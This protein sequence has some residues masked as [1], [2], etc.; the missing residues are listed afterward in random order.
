MKGAQ[1]F[2]KNNNINFIQFEFGHATRAARVNLY[3]IV[4]FLESFGYKLYVVKPLGLLPL[5]YTPFIENRYNYIN[6]LAVN[7]N[8]LKDISDIIIDN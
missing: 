8:S 2:L 1:K 7:K 3:D 5:N 4:F 6:F